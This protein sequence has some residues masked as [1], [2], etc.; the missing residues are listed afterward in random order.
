VKVDGGV[1]RTATTV[2]VSEKPSAM[3][4]DIA[5]NPYITSSSS[6]SYVAP[7]ARLEN[8][9][10]VLAT[11]TNPYHGYM[12]RHNVSFHTEWTLVQHVS[13]S[14]T[15]TWDEITMVD[16]QRLTSEDADVVLADVEARVADTSRPRSSRRRDAVALEAAR[17]EA[18]IQSNTRR[19]VGSYDK[20]WPY[21]GNIVY[22]IAVDLADKA[23][24]SERVQILQQSPPSPTNPYRSPRKRDGLSDETSNPFG[25]MASNKPPPDLKFTT[26]MQKARLGGK[27][28]RL[29]RRF[30]SRRIV[31]F[32]ISS[33]I[34]TQHNV[35][36][37]FAGRIMLVMGRT[38]RAFWATPE[39]DNVFAIETGDELP[40]GLT[41]VGPPMPAFQD[42]MAREC[43]W[44]VPS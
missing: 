43:S 24:S 16:V 3:P 31:T 2:V 44:K 12:S 25:M 28:Y 30:G 42:L 19:G 20:D 34:R 9:R 23:R 29:A 6:S 10:Y 15:I 17:E 14:G 18:D 11:P 8:E 7:G 26:T 13:R 38:Y 35:V 40:E 41:R 4:A 5:Q 1:V 36:D 32:K 37:M 27:S 33:R 22:S 39:G 21:G